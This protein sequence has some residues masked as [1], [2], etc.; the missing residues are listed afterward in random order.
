MNSLLNKLLSSFSLFRAAAE[1]GEYEHVSPWEMEV[2]PEEER[3][4]LEEARKQQQAA[5]RAMRARGATRRWVLFSVAALPWCPALV[6]LV[7][8]S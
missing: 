8:L 2:D 6:R 4:R 5:A 7:L 1:L 3:R